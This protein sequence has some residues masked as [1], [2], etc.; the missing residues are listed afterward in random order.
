ML[1][2][3][4]RQALRRNELFLLFQPCVELSGGRIIGMEALLRWRHPSRGI[5]PPDSFIPLAEAHGSI[6]D[7]GKW[8]L[9]NACVQLRQWHEAGLAGLR[10]AV[11]MSAIQLEATT[12]VH[13][14]IDALDRTGLD[15]R[16]LEIEITETAFIRD[17]A[18]AAATLRALKRLG[19]AIAMDDFGVGYS[20]LGRLRR[21]PVDILKIDKSFVRGVAIDPRRRA[22]VHGMIRMAKMLGLTVV[23]E[24]VETTSE[25]RFLRERQCDRAQGFLMSRPVEA[26][27]IPALVTAM[28]RPASPPISGRAP[29]DHA[30]R[31]NR[32]SA[33]WRPKLVA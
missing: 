7:I 22:I 9:W 1:H 15:A 31:V 28:R 3:E 4:L 8:V 2:D 10:M 13:E 14:V 17:I 33:A 32:M 12:F 21:L 19:A 29:T 30:R 11:N 24:G 16:F 27:K 6:T 20:R 23:A 5:I 26:E 25:Y 18:A